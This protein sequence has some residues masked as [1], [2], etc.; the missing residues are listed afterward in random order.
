MRPSVESAV[1]AIRGLDLPA[2]YEL[3]ARYWKLGGG[4]YGTVF[5]QRDHFPRW[6]VH[7]L[8]EFQKR[9]FSSKGVVTPTGWELSISHHAW[10]SVSIP[11]TGPVSVHV[12]TP[13]ADPASLQLPRLS[14]EALS[15]IGRVSWEAGD[16]KDSTW[17]ASSLD[18]SEVL[19]V[20]VSAAARFVVH[21]TSQ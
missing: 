9:L 18:V 16:W 11:V 14:L 4:G 12:K 15:D 6:Y 3:D 8:S 5:K 17:S 7:V 13:V 2:P 21:R 19:D 20:F 1:E 10:V